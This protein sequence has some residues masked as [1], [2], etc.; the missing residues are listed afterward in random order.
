MSIQL[1]KAKRLSSA[2]EA[3][4]EQDL[5]ANDNK[6]IL[7]H[8]HGD[9]RGTDFEE[10]PAVSMETPQPVKTFQNIDASWPVNV[11]S[12]R[13]IISITFEAWTATPTTDAVLIIRRAGEPF[14]QQELGV[15]TAGSE[16][17]FDLT[18]VGF[19]PFDLIDA[20]LYTFTIVSASGPSVQIELIGDESPDAPFYS[21][22][23]NVLTPKELGYKDDVYPVVQ[24]G[25]KGV[26]FEDSASLQ[27]GGS[28]L[29]HSDRIEDIIS[30]V[31]LQT[32]DETNPKAK[33]PGTFIDANPVF[34]VLTDT[35]TNPVF[36]LTPSVA[37]RLTAITFMSDGA[38]TNVK[39][40][41]V[42][43]A[44]GFTTTEAIV[45]I[46]P[47]S[48]SFD[49]DFT[50]TAIGN[51]VQDIEGGRTYVISVF[52]D[53]GDVL[54]LGETASDEP[55]M[56]I[57]VYPL[58][59][60]IIPYFSNLT[61]LDGTFHVDLNTNVEAPDRDG[62][63]FR[64]FISATE[65]LAAIGAATVDSQHTLL[66]TS[67]DYAETFV[68]PL[69]THLLNLANDP[70]SVR[71]DQVTYSAVGGRSSITRC[72][73][74]TIIYDTTAAGGA[75]LGELTLNN[76]AS[77][78]GI[79]MTGRG[80]GSDKIVID[81][82]SLIDGITP[83]QDVHLVA[84]NAFP[85]TFSG[86]IGII[87]TSAG[88]NLL[89][90]NACFVEIINCDFSEASP[91]TVTG[92][93]GT[94]RLDVKGS[95]VPVFLAAGVNPNVT[96]AR[97]ANSV[98]TIADTVTGGGAIIVNLD[99][100][101]QVEYDNTTSGLTADN[102]NDAIDELSLGQAEL[103]LAGLRNGTIDAAPP[104]ISLKGWDM[105]VAAYETVTFDTS[106]QNA[107]PRAMAIKR[108]GVKMLVLGG[109][110]T[111]Y[112]YTL[113]VADDVS[114]AVYDTVSL[115]VSPGTEDI[116]SMV[117][118]NEGLILLLLDDDGDQ[119]IRYTLSVAW[120]LTTAVQDQV[121]PDLSGTLTTMRSV[122][123]D[124]HANKAW[125]VSD[126]TV[127]QFSMDEDFGIT[128][129]T[130]DSVSFSVS[131]QTT[132]ASSLNFSAD[133]SKMFVTD[134]TGGD[135][136]QYTLSTQLD[137][138]TASYD[139][140]FFD[141]TT[142]ESVPNGV[143]FMRT[144]NTFWVIGSGGGGDIFEYSSDQVQA[145]TF[146]ITPGDLLFVD[147]TDPL[148]PSNTVIKYLG[149]SD[150]TCTQLD[151]QRNVF[152]YIDVSQNPVTIVQ[153]LTVPAEKATVEV[154]LGNMDAGQTTTPFDT[155]LRSNA[156][157]ET[158]FNVTETSSTLHFTRG[159]YNL[160]GLAWAG[161]AINNDL[162]LTHTEGEG[163]RIG[164]SSLVNHLSPDRIEAVA[165]AVS[166][167]V[168]QHIDASGDTITQPGAA[169]IDPTQYNNAGSLAAVSPV[170]RFTIQYVYFFY[171]SNSVRCQFGDTLYN[172]IATAEADIR[173]RPIVE[174]SQ[175]KETV[176]T[177]AIIVAGNATDL[178]MAA[179]AKFIRL[180]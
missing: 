57:D 121:S 175:V 7:S 92:S 176:L 21:W 6:V 145:T 58:S 44:T 11:S 151:I 96:I 40:K 154:Y 173:K 25:I 171:G 114:T 15:I 144:G 26:N 138:S 2:G 22:E 164:V 97:D 5:I 132:N 160:R 166:T 125:I 158:A 159:E 36:N 136:H 108:D 147:R 69:F 10:A 20:T 116:V 172:D 95:K 62:S 98:F 142:Q 167:I 107:A 28:C 17:T 89:D 105:A 24:T 35:L 174:S 63:V 53:D 128:D 101:L 87:G 149:E 34:T 157:P 148:N 3:L 75:S 123:S 52:S 165:D 168:M 4:I 80:A 1:G 13:R 139:S 19:T 146:D 170:S 126:D 119:L 88:T 59:D 156:F 93:T 163:I 140:V 130:Y 109:D 66:F 48:G 106:T 143:F 67:G 72:R 65:A 8:T 85:N 23:F 41:F 33:Q 39:V 29:F 16:T 56:T 127:F 118:L 49:I 161:D 152:V 31:V 82:L 78:S 169:V 122:W 110:Q 100:A 50:D 135:I 45:A 178:S 137:L 37:L 71:F 120:D 73:I 133:A 46:Q 111:I 179:Q 32:F 61:V 150:I 76:V 155:L 180:V 117:T 99:K 43:Q 38:Q 9:E 12:D 14:Y 162:S 77:Q 153:K 141:T 86:N 83:C 54:L 27:Q 134:L 91:S 115:G 64:P 112:Q 84:I 113:S 79:D 177:A 74:A 70:E 102:V 18:A 42:D 129:L 51:V 131:G 55:W 60:Q 81:S 47:A 124:Q 90:G 68:L 30:A 104:E 103:A 94:V